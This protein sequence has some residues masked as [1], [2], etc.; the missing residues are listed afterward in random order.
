MLGDMDNIT[1][2]SFYLLVILSTDA[3]VCQVK[4]Q[5]TYWIH[6][7]YQDYNPGQKRL[8]LKEKVAEDFLKWGQGGD[9][10]AGKEKGATEE[11]L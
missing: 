3:G 5:V 4:K 9:K 6:D 10:M 2:N 11:S 1:C 7:F 8:F